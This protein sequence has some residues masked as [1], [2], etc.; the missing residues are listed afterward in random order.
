[1]QGIDGR[2]RPV[3]RDAEVDE[4][5][6]EAREQVLGLGHPRALAQQPVAQGDTLLERAERH[7]VRLGPVGFGGRCRLGQASIEHM[8]K[9]GSVSGDGNRRRGPPAADP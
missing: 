8:A 2:G 1:M 9:V 3:Y 7:V 6:G 5:L 4:P